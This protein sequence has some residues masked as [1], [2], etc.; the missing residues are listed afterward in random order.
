M[1]WNPQNIVM[2]SNV[3]IGLALTS[4]AA[5]VVCEATFSNVRTTGAVS[6][7]WTNQDIGITTNAA[8]PLYVAIS[9]AGGVP[10]VVANSDPLAAT[11]DAWTNWRVPLQVFADQGVNLRNVDKIAIGLGSKSG[12]ASAGGSG[13][14]YVDD[15]R[16]YRP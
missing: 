3:H 16:L 4:H 7:Q 10:A 6:G 13:A 2:G 11:I 5:G 15:I 9:N 8:E 14:I 12:I 1:T